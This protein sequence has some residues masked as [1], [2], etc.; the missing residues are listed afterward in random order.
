MRVRDRKQKR[1]W[2]EEEEGKKGEAVVM[3]EGPSDEAID[4]R[5]QLVS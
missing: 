5:E 4:G 1:G 3:H 2:E